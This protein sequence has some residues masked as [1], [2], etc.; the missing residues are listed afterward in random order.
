[1]NKT[2][3]FHLNHMS[4]RGT[5]VSIFNYAKYNQTLLGNKSIIIVNRKKVF[6]SLEKF[7]IDIL[8]KFNFANKNKVKLFSKRQRST[9]LKFTENFKVFF[10]DNPREIDLICR[11]NKVD[12]FYAQKYGIV[13]SV[14]SNYCKNLIH[15]IFMAKEPHG[16]KYLYISEW[17][18]KKMTGDSKNYVPYI[19][20]S[21]SIDYDGNLRKQLNIP[22]QHVVISSYGGKNVFDIPFVKEA[23]KEVLDLRNDIVFMFLNI[24]PF[25][26]HSRIHFLPRS[27]DLK[28]KS[29]FI[30]TSDYMI[31]A[32]LRGETF[33][34]AIAE[35]SIKNKPIITYSNSPEKAHLE[36]LGDKSLNYSSKE[37]LIK[38]LINL[39]K[40]PSQ[41]K[42]NF[43][44][45]YS[46][47]FNP[48]TV[49]KLFEER[50]LK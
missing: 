17:L 15:V 7:L 36:M 27:V 34:L 50:F 38:I 25:F 37:D 46:E 31:H 12:Y 14:F 45:C 29:Q 8:V 30:N 16:D 44:D 22:D 5:E 24:E 1:M 48:K 35:F 28:Q 33:G 43:F 19:V 23:I 41:P 2:I 40:S 26:K 21:K 10:Y 3:A 11:E 9:F 13:D 4:E 49:M 32:R 39:K 47:K 18:S 20:D 42:E 6:N